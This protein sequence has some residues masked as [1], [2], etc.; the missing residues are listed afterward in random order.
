VAAVFDIAVA[1]HLLRLEV[2]NSEAA[3]IT[4]LNATLLGMMQEGPLKKLWRISGLAQS[5]A[6]ARCLTNNNVKVTAL[7]RPP[8]VVVPTIDISVDGSGRPQLDINFPGV[9]AAEALIDL[10][11]RHSFDR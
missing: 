3:L 8:S 10:E 1:P 7:P 2:D 9:A 6:R 4:V 11:F 5:A